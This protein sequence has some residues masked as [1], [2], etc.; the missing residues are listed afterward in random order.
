MK[1]YVFRVIGEN[2]YVDKDFFFEGADNESPRPFIIHQD[3]E[4]RDLAVVPYKIGRHSFR[5]KV[6]DADADS[7]LY[8]SVAFSLPNGNHMINNKV[9][10]DSKKGYKLSRNDEKLMKSVAA[11]L[12]YFMADEFIA[13]S[14]SSDKK[15]SDALNDKLEKYSALSEEEQE[16]AMEMGLQGISKEE[17]E[18]RQKEAK[19]I[20]NQSNKKSSFEKR[21]EMMNKGKKR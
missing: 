13:Y 12:I 3:N 7:H 15:I 11:G 20:N 8:P 16:H 14:K 18:R 17:D 4:D 5:L 19:K 21:L 6:G 1:V 2:Y 10:H 9:S